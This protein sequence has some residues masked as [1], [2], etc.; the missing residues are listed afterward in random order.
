MSRRRRH[1]RCPVCE[2]VVP[3]HLEPHDCRLGYDEERA[4][5]TARGAD[6]AAMTLKLRCEESA[7][8]LQDGAVDLAY[9][10]KYARAFVAH[11]DAVRERRRTKTLARHV[12]QRVLMLSAWA[13][14]WR[15]VEAGQ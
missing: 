9:L 15:R 5:R 13:A 3:A 4:R 1:P 6:T 8:P 11:D 7:G 12:R 14:F 10:R 2:T